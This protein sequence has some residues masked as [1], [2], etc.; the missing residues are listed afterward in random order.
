M[1]TAGLASIL[2]TAL[3]LFEGKTKLVSQTFDGA[4]AMSGKV[5]EVQTLMK[6]DYPHAHFSFAM[7]IS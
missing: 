7:L 6:Q 1:S 2:K 4:A 5:S 3:E